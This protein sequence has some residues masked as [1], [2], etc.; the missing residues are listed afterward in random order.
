MSS[1]LGLRALGKEDTRVIIRTVLIY[2]RQRPYKIIDQNETSCRLFFMLL[3]AY[4]AY[5]I[6]IFLHS[7]DL[8]LITALTEKRE[9]EWNF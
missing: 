1:L 6:F 5:N 4:Q 3:L 2:N 8:S 9:L 7:L